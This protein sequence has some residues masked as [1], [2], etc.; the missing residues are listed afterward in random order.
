MGAECRGSKKKDFLKWDDV[1]NY[2]IGEV[3]LLPD[4]FWRMTW[5][6]V[7]TACEGYQRRL[8]R[9]LELQR[10]TAAVLINANRSK[11][12]KMVRPEDIMPLITDKR[13]TEKS[14]LMTAEEFEKMKELFSKVKW[15]A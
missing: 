4:D 10:F 8:A 7:E 13:R 1:L 3:G 12:S 11:G 2:C 14:E 15:Q 9:T 6:E 5:T